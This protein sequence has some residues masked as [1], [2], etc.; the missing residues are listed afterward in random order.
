MNKVAAISPAVS[1][2][3]GNPRPSLLRA[4]N[5]IVE[6]PRDGRPPVRVVDQV[7]L[8]VTRGEVVGIVGESGSGKSMTARALMRLTPPGGKVSGEIVLGGEEVMT[9]SNDAL[10]NMRG[11]KVAMVFQDPM[12]SFNPVRRVGEQIGEAITIHRYLP[13]RVLLERVVSLLQ[14]VGIVRP[15][16][17]AKAYPQEFSGGMRQRALI[18]MSMANDP[19]LLIADEPTTALDVTVQDQVLDVMRDLNSRSATTI[20]LITHNIAV[21]AS[22]CTRVVVMY[23][24]RVV[25]DGPVGEILANPQHPY[26]WMLLQSVPRI[27]KQVDRLVAIEGHPPDPA[28]LP[29]GCKFHPRCPFSVDRCRVEDPILQSVGAMHEARCHVLMR[30]AGAAAHE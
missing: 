3:S 2:M 13:G 19:E 28:E 20:L 5:I 16:E 12:T 23:A 1:L 6:F 29:T 27:D 22:I 8:E 17:R 26:T 11:T 4:R 10:R 7:S 15:A 25:E 9:L 24:G 30:N 18:A 21:V 14:S